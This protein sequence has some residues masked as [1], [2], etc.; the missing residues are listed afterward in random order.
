MLFRNYTN[1]KVLQNVLYI[2]DSFYNLC[3]KALILYV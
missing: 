3:F 2:L 1:F